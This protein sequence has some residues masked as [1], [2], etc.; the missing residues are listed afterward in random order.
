MTKARLIDTHRHYWGVGWDPVQRVESYTQGMYGVSLEEA[1]YR[2]KQDKDG[3]VMMKQVEE[4]DI[5]TVI[6]HTVDSGLAYPGDTPTDIEHINKFQCEMAERY[7]G[8]VYSL[9]GIDPRRPGGIKMFEKAVKEWGAI[10]LSFWPIAGFYANDPIC[11]AYYQK[12]IDLDVPVTIH[13]GAQ[14]AS[15]LLNKYG[16]PIHVEEIARDLPDL[17]II[18]C[19]TGFDKY[20]SDWFWEKAVIVASCKPNVYVDV[21]DWQREYTC[22]VLADMPKFWYKMKT[23]RHVLGANKIMFGTDMP[24][25]KMGHVESDI[26]LTKQWVKIFRNLPEEGK[27]YGATFTEEEA[28]LIMHGNAE[29]VFKV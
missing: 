10:G 7:K 2:Y 21:A 17:K 19:H 22:D 28:A 29:R 18:M 15:G 25:Y 13:T 27:K 11:Y 5:D 23:M 20:P 16:D 4:F 8:K 26:K 3:S 24:S 9:F 12:C 6:L 14:H 1:W